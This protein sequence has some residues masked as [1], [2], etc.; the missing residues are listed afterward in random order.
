MSEGTAGSAD[1]ASESDP[2]AALP[3]IEDEPMPECLT[4]AIAAADEETRNAVAAA[5]LGQRARARKPKGT[6]AA[7]AAALAVKK[8]IREKS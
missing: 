3:S 5:W 7:S 4:K 8:T 1:E 2:D 6:K